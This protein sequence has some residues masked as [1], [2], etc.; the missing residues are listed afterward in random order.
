MLKDNIMISEESLL[1][2]V[3]FSER[4][5][6]ECEIWRQEEGH[7][8]VTKQRRVWPGYALGHDQLQRRKDG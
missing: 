2:S 3:G 7:I 6:S 8:A 1:D 5:I 4:R